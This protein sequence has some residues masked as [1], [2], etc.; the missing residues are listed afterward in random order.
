MWWSLTTDLKATFSMNVKYARC[1]NAWENDDFERAC[2]QEGMGIQ[3]EY[4]M[5]GTQ[6]ENGR[7]KFSTLKEYLQFSTVENYLLS[8]E[9]AYGLKQPTLPLFLRT[10]YLLQQET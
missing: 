5:P 6:Q 2:R 8:W 1:D 9:M 4:T 7:E 10:T 3:F